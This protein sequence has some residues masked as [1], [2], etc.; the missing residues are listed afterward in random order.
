[1]S[2]RSAN[3]LTLRVPYLALIALGVGTAVWATWIIRDLLLSVVMA[4]FIAI[5]FV[6]LRTLLF[7]RL[8]PR[9][10]LVASLLTTAALLL[11]VLPT[12]FVL[13]LLVA[14]IL[15]VLATLKRELGS[16]G[17]EGLF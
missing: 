14:E 9:P 12:A 8:G 3:N 10:Q 5:L 6:P 4:A 15:D 2:R 7:R 11:I 16:Q 17:V 13:Y 1:M